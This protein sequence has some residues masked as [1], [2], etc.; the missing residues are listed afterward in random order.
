MYIY[1]YNTYTSAG[2]SRLRTDLRP[3]TPEAP[4]RQ[5]AAHDREAGPAETPI[6]NSRCVY[7]YIYI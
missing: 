3:A 1:I 2:G 6:E 7:I 5:H 4:E